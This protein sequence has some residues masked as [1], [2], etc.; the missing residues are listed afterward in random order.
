MPAGYCINLNYYKNGTSLGTRLLHIRQVK[1]PRLVNCTKIWT[2][3]K[4]KR[5]SVPDGSTTPYHTTL[6]PFRMDE[7]LI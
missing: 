4:T 1:R 2:S 7:R 6:H 3:S 5:N